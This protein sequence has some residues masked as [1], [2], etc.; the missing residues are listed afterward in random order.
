MF[1]LKLT[2]NDRSF[3]HKKIKIKANDRQNNIKTTL[4]QKIKAIGSK[5]NK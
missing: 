2:P 4:V 3:K 5:R 1:P